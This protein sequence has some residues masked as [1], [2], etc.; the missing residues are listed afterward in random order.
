LRSAIVAKAISISLSVFTLSGKGRTCCERAVSSSA[1]DRLSASVI[2]EVCAG[3]LSLSPGALAGWSADDEESGSVGAAMLGGGTSVSRKYHKDDDR[4]DIT[5]ITDTPMMQGID[6]LLGGGMV[7]SGDMKLSI[8]D[9]RKVTYTKSENSYQTMVANK[10]L[11]KVEGSK[12]VDD[13][14]LRTYLAAVRFPEE[15]GAQ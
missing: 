1:L 3:P 5:L 14:T 10:A 15:K 9:G 2:S 8:I 7:S 12:G 13:G 11:I 6:A 4:V